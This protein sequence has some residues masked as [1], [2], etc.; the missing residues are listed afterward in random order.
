MIY[1]DASFAVSLYSTD[2]NSHAALNVLPP[3]GAILILTNLAELETVNAVALRVFRKAISSAEADA[4]LHAFEEDLHNGVFLRRDV[5]ASSFERARKLSLL[6]TA[7]MGTRTA[8]LLHVAA[9]LELGANS[10]FSFDLR[11]RKVAQDSG[12]MLNPLP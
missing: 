5:A 12:L 9:A 8:D 6:T 2:T 7:R 10:F 4:S 3:S 11:Q 1:F